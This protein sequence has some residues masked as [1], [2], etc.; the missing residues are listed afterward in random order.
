MTRKEIDQYL[1]GIVSLGVVIFGIWFAVALVVSIPVLLDE[2]LEVTLIDSALVKGW[3]SDYDSLVWGALI[4]VFLYQFE[5]RRLYKNMGQEG[6]RNTFFSDK[7]LSGDEQIVFKR[8]VELIS[9]QMTSLPFAVETMPASPFLLGYLSAFAKQ[10]QRLCVDIDP[11]GTRHFNHVYPMARESGMT[12]AAEELEPLFDY[13]REVGNSTA[14]TKEF[15]LGSEVGFSDYYHGLLNRLGEDKGFTT[16]NLRR[17]LT[18]LDLNYEDFTDEDGS[19]CF[20]DIK[21]VRALTDRIDELKALKG[22]DF[23]VDAGAI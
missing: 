21:R 16:D 8:N 7:L 22:I 12:L 10:S 4:A 2:Y 19:G 6:G 9:H 13:M 11:E 17:W 15:A 5:K 14:M 1:D 18:G 3:F 20:R 23:P